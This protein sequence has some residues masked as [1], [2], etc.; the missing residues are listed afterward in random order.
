MGASAGTLFVFVLV[1]MA[2]FSV[3]GVSTL[4][5]VMMIDGD[6]GYLEF[7]MVLLIS[8]VSVVSC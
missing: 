2:T 4:L 7:L 8:F 3:C 1:V 5:V 6:G